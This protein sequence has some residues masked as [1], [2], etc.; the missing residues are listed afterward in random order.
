MQQHPPTL[1]TL[2]STSALVEA[3]VAHLRRTMAGTLEPGEEP[4]VTSRVYEWMP[5]HMAQPGG[6]L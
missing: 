2:E 5:S 6:A 4:A 3:A 1:P